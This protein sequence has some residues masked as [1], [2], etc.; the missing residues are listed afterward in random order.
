M[1]RQ[2]RACPF[3]RAPSRS[4]VRLNLPWLRRAQGSLLAFSAP[5]VRLFLDLFS[6]YSAPVSSA[7]HVLSGD[8]FEPVDILF[9]SFFD[10]LSDEA[11]EFLL[12]LADSTL[13]GAVLA[14]PHCGEYSLL[15]L[16]CPGP[17][18]L[19]TPQQLQGVEGL[20]PVDQLRLQ[21]SAVLHDRA[22]LILL[23]VITHHGLR[24]RPPP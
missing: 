3:Q 18:P 23:R 10:I 4:H 22:R 11:F 9:D 2:I 12:R 5:Q 19:R 14:A 20:L 7:V 1:C 8:A 24:I 13:I 15:S 16:R 6:G 17:Q 21:D